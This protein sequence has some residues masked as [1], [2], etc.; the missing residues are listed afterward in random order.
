[1]ATA[2]HSPLGKVLHV[3]REEL[4]RLLSGVGTKENAPAAATA[5][6]TNPQEGDQK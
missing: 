3:T 6:A 2:V 1:M 5:R 4:D